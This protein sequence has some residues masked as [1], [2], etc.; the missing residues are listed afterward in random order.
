MLKLVR[1]GKW[2]SG[3]IRQPER[4]QRGLVCLGYPSSYPTVEWILDIDHPMLDGQIGVDPF[5][6]LAYCCKGGSTKPVAKLRH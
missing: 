3:S 4:R 6:N 5:L 1:L 2:A